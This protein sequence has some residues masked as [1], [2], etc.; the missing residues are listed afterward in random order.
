[1]NDA[2]SDA[3]QNTAAAATTRMAA[4]REAGDERLAYRGIF[5]R[6]LTRPE[7]GAAIAALGIW[8]FFWAVSVPFGKAS[9]A[10][11]ILDVASS[12]LGIM[13]VAVA[14][15]MREVVGAPN[16][17]WGLSLWLAIP[18]S[19]CAALGLGWFN[20]TVV[21][22]TELPSFIVTLGSFFVL[23]GAKLGFSK[24]IVGQ[25]Q[26]GK[27]D[28]LQAVQAYIVNDQV[29]VIDPDDVDAT[30]P[31]G[32]ELFEVVPPVID[33]IEDNLAQGLAAFAGLDDSVF[34]TGDRGYGFLVKM[35]AG[36]WGRNDHIW[37]GRDWFY[38]IGVVAGLS[39]MALAL[40]EMHFKRRDT[41]NPAGLPVFLGGVAATV[42]GVWRLHATDSVAGNWIGAAIIGVGMAIGFVGWGM[43]RYKTRASLDDALGNVA[44]SAGDV[45]SSPGIVTPLVMGLVSFAAAIG[46]A[47]WL[48]SSSEDKF[49]ATLGLSGLAVP[50]VALLVGI[51][52]A[53][54][55]KG[56]DFN[57]IRAGAL[58]DM[59]LQSMVGSVVIGFLITMLFFDITTEQGARA[60]FFVALT[61]LAFVSLS[62]AVGRG[63]RQ[64]Q[65]LGSA[66]LLLSAGAVG[67]MAFFVQS[68]STSEKFRTQAFSFIVVI[69]A[70][71][72]I[73]A[74]ASLLFEARSA[75]DALADRAGTIMGVAGA[76]LAILGLTSR[77]LFV[78]GAE[79]EAGMPP[80]RFSVR[81]LWFFIFT[82][83]CSWV[84]ARTRFGSWT[85]AVGGNKQA[86][87]QVGV[88]AARTKT[89]LFMLVSAA[90]W[91]VGLLLAFR[92]N[93]IQA[94]T[95]DGQEFQYIIA[96]VVGGTFLTGGYGST[97]GAAIGAVII[98]MARQGI[99]S[100]RWNSD[101][102]FVFIGTILL[103][104]VVANNFIRAKAEASR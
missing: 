79:L 35:F 16:G 1:M 58:N 20:G 57:A 51:G 91:L 15:L 18:L 74:I 94:N 54:L 64:S 61:V 55:L 96:A 8:I 83:V 53:L 43:W 21:E 14:M 62:I 80:S 92:L 38:T 72:A 44:A 36:E 30:V 59:R 82:V 103:L 42:V 28:D 5:Q 97:I 81:I 31:E 101:W 50:L 41:M 99:P 22:K 46:I 37:D 3:L 26:V 65:P 76:V 69:A 33:I 60:M 70:L 19:L 75:P 39:L 63:R 13:A 87:R 40:Y 93:N 23:V 104:A 7:I 12:P 86:A 102:R 49:S 11:S 9:G 89:Q 95:G 73:W 24:L 85:F 90:A 66:L 84:L 6:I 98:A 25:Q 45:S 67:A 48:D 47:V 88:P 77:L 32:A 29:T 100:A 17:G 27:L 34:S 10:A 71:M 56:R 2:A 78:T 68:Q 52:A 4:D